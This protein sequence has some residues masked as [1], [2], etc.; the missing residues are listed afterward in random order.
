MQKSLVRTFKPSYLC[1]P[2][3]KKRGSSL[4]N[5]SLTNSKSAC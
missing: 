2:Q 5:G 1:N 3:M 4:K